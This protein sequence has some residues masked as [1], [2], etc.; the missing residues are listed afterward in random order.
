MELRN[1]V[2]QLVE[3]H[4]HGAASPPGCAPESAAPTRE[5]TSGQTKKKPQ[6]NLKSI[7]VNHVPYVHIKISNI[8]INDVLHRN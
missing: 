7:V 5:E 2:P 3:L 8:N 4:G 1:Y 6:Q